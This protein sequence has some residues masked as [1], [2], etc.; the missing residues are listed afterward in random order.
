M[1]L[2]L[3]V[4]A[5]LLLWLSLTAVCG[6]ECVPPVARASLLLS[7]CLCRALRLPE[8]GARQAASRRLQTDRAPGAGTH[9]LAPPGCPSRSE[10]LRASG[11]LPGSRA[12]HPTWW[13]V[14]GARPS[15]L[16]GQ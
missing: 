8:P 9:R 6:G 2:R 10:K 14:A 5:L 16:V 13:R 12:P 4:Q 7:R 11:V 1:N 15:P 3:C